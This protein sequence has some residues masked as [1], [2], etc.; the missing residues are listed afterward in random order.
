L[1]HTSTPT[2]SNIYLGVDHLRGQYF[3]L[4][5]QYDVLQSLTIV[6]VNGLDDMSSIKP[7]GKLQHL[8]SLHIELSVPGYPTQIGWT[9][10]HDTPFTDDD[11]QTMTSGLPLLHNFVLR[12]PCKLS[13]PALT[14]LATNCPRIKT[15]DLSTAI[16]IAAWRAQEAPTFSELETLILTHGEYG[17][18]WGGTA[19]VTQWSSPIT[20]P[21]PTMKMV[22]ESVIDPEH[23]D[24][25][26]RRCLKLERLHLHLRDYDAEELEKARKRKM[27][28][29]WLETVLC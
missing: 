12:L 5:S 19:R 13:L 26:A 1:A 2:L 9:Q 24:V 6:A 11:F 17:D 27:R 28:G 7:L 29:G 14:S 20:Q 10:T 4:V 22:D 21:H 3:Q 18:T 8:R 25:I 15:C 16:P 23:V